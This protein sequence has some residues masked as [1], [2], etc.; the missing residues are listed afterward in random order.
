MPFSSTPSTLST[1]RNGCFWD[2]ILAVVF[3][4]LKFPNSVLWR[5]IHLPS[6]STGLF[7]LRILLDV[8]PDVL[9]FS[10]SLLTTPYEPHGGYPG[11]HTFFC[12]TFHSVS[13]VLSLP[14]LI[15]CSVLPGRVICCFLVFLEP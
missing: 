3:P 8:F 13:C 6:G 15:L 7:P 11:W 12:A 10:E 14:G 4:C 2:A 5:R 9:L 1:T